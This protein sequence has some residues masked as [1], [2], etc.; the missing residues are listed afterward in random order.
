MKIGDRPWQAGPDTLQGGQPPSSGDHVDIGAL[1]HAAPRSYARALKRSPP[2]RRAGCSSPGAARAHCQH[3]RL[4]L[5]SR[6]APSRSAR[7]PRKQRRIPDLIARL[8][9]ALHFRVCSGGEKLVLLA[10]SCPPTVQ[11]RY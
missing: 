2:V 6:H 10:R 1:E 11:R 8:A 4:F 5:P 7:D 3:D 9:K